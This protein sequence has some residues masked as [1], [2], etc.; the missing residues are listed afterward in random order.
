MTDRRE[1]A[2][3]DIRRAQML[4]VLDRKVIEGQQCL[5]IFDEACDGRLVFDGPDFDEGIERCERILLG[6]GQCESSGRSPL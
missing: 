1:R 3:H 4:P 6:L 5:A 2:F